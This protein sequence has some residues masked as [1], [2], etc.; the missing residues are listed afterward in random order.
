M[1]KRPWSY[2]WDHGRQPHS[3]I[4]REP[5]FPH[6]YHQCPKEGPCKWCT[7]S[8]KRRQRAALLGTKEER[9]AKVAEWLKAKEKT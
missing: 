5:E 6:S 4:V 2:G 8:K 7:K 3:R 1:S 9:E